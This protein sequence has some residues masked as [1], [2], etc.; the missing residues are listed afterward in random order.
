MIAKIVIIFIL[1]NIIFGMASPK[2][3]AKHS[4]AMAMATPKPVKALDTG[5]IHHAC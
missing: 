3:F 1:L 4:L 5:S 2:L